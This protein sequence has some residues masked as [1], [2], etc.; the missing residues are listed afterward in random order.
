MDEL[1][2]LNNG[3]QPEKTT[4]SDILYS[5]APR[6]RRRMPW[7]GVAVALILLG[8]ALFAVGWLSGSRG[9]RIYFDRGIRVETGDREDF[10]PTG[11]GNFTFANNFDSLV[12]N[13]SSRA[14]RIFPSSGQDVRVT[15]PPDLRIEINEQGRTLDIDTRA[16]TTGSTRRIHFMTFGGARGVTFNRAGGTG[17]LNF[18][19]DFT[20]PRNIWATGGI[21]VYVPDSVNDI[22]ARTSSGSVRIND[23]STT[24]LRA[25]TSSG[26]VEVNGGTHQDVHLQTSSG[27][28]IANGYFSGALHAQTS[29]GRVRVHDYNNRRTGSENIQ[30]RSSSGSVRFYTR[31]PL[32][33][34]NYRI[35]VTSGSM[36]VDDNR[37]SG[38][39]ASGGS[40]GT[41]I[42]ASTTSG[43]VRL[44]FSQ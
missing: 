38:R 34:F 7:G 23:V 13:A 20:N 33:D 35:S 29:S 15:V 10:V 25:Q 12:V 8:I 43:G 4:D 31:A 6:P 26:R 37:I 3:P 14:I 16:R 40:G 28:V 24:N 44:N 32:S 27:S 21:R 2:P 11:N 1:K 30:L 22:Y 5:P 9:G 41:T 19:F 17:Y 36:R 39:N 42:N 18:D